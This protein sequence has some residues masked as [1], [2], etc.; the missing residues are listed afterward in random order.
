MTSFLRAVT[1]R[2]EGL[3]RQ[4]QAKFFYADIGATGRYGKPIFK[5][6]PELRDKWDSYPLAPWNYLNEKRC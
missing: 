6:H 5:H 3:A 2:F 4:P 1:D